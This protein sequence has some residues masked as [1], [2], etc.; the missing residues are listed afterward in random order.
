[1]SLTSSFWKGC[2]PREAEGSPFGTAGPDDDVLGIDEEMADPTRPEREPSGG[3]LGLQVAFK[4][5]ASSVSGG[6]NS[7][8]SSMTIQRVSSG[9]RISQMNGKITSC[10]NRRRSLSLQKTFPLCSVAGG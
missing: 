2:V 1:M 6:Q 8:S 7:M 10:E 4:N 9:K 5:V 3:M